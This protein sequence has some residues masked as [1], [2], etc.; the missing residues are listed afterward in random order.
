MICHVYRRGR[1]YWGKLQLDHEPHLSRLSLGTTDKRV[2]MTKLWEIAKQREKE[3][4]GLL[5]PQST[6]EAAGKPLPDVLTAFLDDLQVK[7]RAAAT[8]SKYR[9]SL[10]KLFVRCHWKILRDVSARS[11]CEW[12]SRCGLRAKSLND[13]LGEVMCFM[14]WLVHQR[15]IM[16]NPLA[17]VQRIDTRGSAG[18]FRRCLGTVELARLLEVAPAKRRIVYFTAA[19]TG[20]RRSEMNAL[21]WSDV[22][23]DAAAPIIR[24][25][26][27]ITKNR[28]DAVIPLHVDLAAALRAHR[29]ADAAPFSLVLKGLVPRI[30]TL[31]K[32]LVKAEIPF[33]DEQGRRADLHALRVT[34]G[35]N[36]TL[37]GAAP[38]VVMELM[39]HSDIKLTMKIYTDAGKLPLAAAV[40]NLP[41]MPAKTVCPETCPKTCPDGGLDQ[42]EGV[43]S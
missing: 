12:R 14:G 28:K 1:L 36:L 42:S 43:A 18:Q 6:R 15:M 25:R 21:R 20:L 17:H 19:Y 24:V 34:Y 16:D 10:T 37:A 3:E 35:T 33:L 7:G 40:A 23:L 2:A 8:L 13:L 38:R 27:S 32:D 31:R 30:T 26:A 41:A 9:N 29:P 22:L 5:A 11:F 39:R 4:A